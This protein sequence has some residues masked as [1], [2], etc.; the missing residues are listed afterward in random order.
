MQAKSDFRRQVWRVPAGMVKEKMHPTA[1]SGCTETGALM[2]DLTRTYTN[3]SSGHPWQ[4]LLDSA[5]EGIWGVDLAGNCTFVNR[6]AL[7]MLGYESHELVGRNMH[8]MVH[9]HYPD[10]REYPG[11]DCVIYSVFRKNRPFSN[12]LDHVFRKD[13]SLFYTEMSAQPILEDGAVRGAVVTFR[14]VTQARLSEEALRRSEKLAA[15]G[16]LASSIAHEIN[17]PLESV[18]NLLYLVKTADTRDEVRTY[19]SLAEQELARISDITMQTLQFHRQQTIPAPVDLRE[20]ISAVLRL[21]TARFASRHVCVKLRLRETPE[22]ILLEGDLRQVLNNLIRNAYDAMP[23]GGTLSIRLRSACNPATNAPGLRI[24]V[25]DT[26]SGFLPK[27]RQ[28][29]FEPFHTSKDVTGTGLGL[30]ISKGIIDKH[31]GRIAM[32]SRL[33]E[34]SPESHGTAFSIWLP[35]KIEPG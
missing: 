19:A 29:L 13:G 6:A 33:E 34:H 25:A 24:C 30:W 9:H 35:L 27:M 31:N 16:Q 3:E 10:G 14:D 18:I 7:A 28:H 5:G 8:R 32:K 23:K 15:V 4:A 21:Y 17:N 20:T 26:G 1:S 11:E 12:Q 2:H 22:A